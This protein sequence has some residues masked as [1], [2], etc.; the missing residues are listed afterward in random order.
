MLNEQ[1]LSIQ[2]CNMARGDVRGV[3]KTLN[4]DLRQYAKLF[5]YT[6]VESGGTFDNIQD[7]ELYT[8]IRLGNDLINNYYEVRIPLKR[9]VWGATSESDIWPTQNDL[10]L[11]LQRLID[12]KVQRNNSGPVNDYYSQIDDDGKEYAIYGNPNLGE[13]RVLFLGVENRRVIMHVPKF[14]SMNFA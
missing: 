2:V 13:V 4:L 9:T 10:E 12:L 3:F 11:N 8:V 5:M 6:H 1:S 7:N 14:G